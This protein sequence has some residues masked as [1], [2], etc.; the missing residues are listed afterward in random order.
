MIKL[1]SLSTD[2]LKALKQ[3]EQNITKGREFSQIIL[4]T[5]TT[6]LS[7]LITYFSADFKFYFKTKAEP[8]KELFALGSLS[9]FT[10][11]TDKKVISN[12][13]KEHDF[14]KILGGERF[15]KKELT[16]SKEDKWEGLEEML[17]FIPRIIFEENEIKINL[18][19]NE[20]LSAITIELLELL[21]TSND[22]DEDNFILSSR[23]TPNQEEW[24][25]MIAKAHFAFEE[26]IFDKVVLH[27]QEVVT[28]SNDIN[29]EEEF[30]K[31]VKDQN[32]P[33]YLLYFKYEKS[34]AFMSV[35]PE[36]LFRT[37]D[38]LLTIDSLAGTIARGITTEEDEAL[39]T[40][41]LNDPKELSEHRFVTNY[42][43]NLLETNHGDKLSNLQKSGIE[44][45]LKLKF[46]Q[47]IHTTIS[48]NVEKG[49]D[50]SLLT[51]LHPTPAVGGLPK[52]SAMDFILENETETRGFYAAPMGYFSKNE[53]DMCV[54]I[55]CAR[56]NSNEI[57]IYGG[58]GVVKESLALNEWNETAV[59][60]QNFQKFLRINK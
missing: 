45:I 28:F 51:S 17:Y 19:T 41:L 31:L 50:I 10:S 53:S 57:A 9:T 60:M 25:A 15:N 13:L 59:K 3:G 12:I 23:L 14:I 18:R 39:A 37:N 16:S 7:S 2:L 11:H 38:G 24:S 47:H 26:K 30:T 49:E 43:T 35:T 1:S 42:I 29:S 52:K 33:S 40:K 36:C 22:R 48:A 55:R 46:V 6:K 44:T 32:S 4:K 56:V 8:S 20:N 21:S 27:R 58:C 54:A 5:E 34:K